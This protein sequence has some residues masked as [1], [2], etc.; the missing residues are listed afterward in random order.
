M[1]GWIIFWGCSPISW[2]SRMQCATARSSSEAEFMSLS[3][4]SQECLYLQMF[5]ALLNILMSMLE[6]YANNI[7]HHTDSSNTPEEKYN[8][9]VKIWSN[10]QVALAQAKKP[11]HWIISKLRHICMAYF[12]FKSY[13]HV[14]N[15]SLHSIPGSNNCS[16]CMTKGYSMPGKTSANQKADL[17]QKH[18]LACLSRPNVSSFQEAAAAAAVFIK[19]K[20]MSE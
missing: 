1:T 3:S 16:N 4:C 11:E 18:A 5:V 20:L 15:L 17:F 6:I 19:S 10:C 7:S 9:A 8:L 2:C 14:G 13:V 12:F